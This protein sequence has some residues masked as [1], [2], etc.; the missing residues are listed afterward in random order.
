MFGRLASAALDMAEERLE[1]PAS[2]PPE[3]EASEAGWL[4][5]A[6]PDETARYRQLVQRPALPAD[7]ASVEYLFIPG[8]MTERWGGFLLALLARG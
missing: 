7:A 2:P 4:G 6:G 3:P 8:L 1:A 5:P